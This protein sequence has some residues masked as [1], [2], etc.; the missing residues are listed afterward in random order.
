[1][2]EKDSRDP[3]KRWPADFPVDLHIRHSNLVDSRPTPSIARHP[4]ATHLL[5]HLERLPEGLLDS[6]GSGSRNEWGRL[7]GRGGL[8][9][10]PITSLKLEDWISLL[11][12]GDLCF[13]RQ[14]ISFA[15]KGEGQGS[16]R[17][18][19][20]CVEEPRW[21]TWGVKVASA[22]SD[23]VGPESVLPRRSLL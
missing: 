3:R 13:F 23:V 11:K 6:S 21:R 17:A 1:M 8:A 4:A 10:F 2:N 20:T 19:N 15:T 9:S 22:L 7:N 16:S 12:L 5:G 18:A 14:D